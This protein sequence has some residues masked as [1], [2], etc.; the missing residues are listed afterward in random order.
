[1]IACAPWASAVRASRRRSQQPRPIRN[2]LI[3]LPFPS[4][5]NDLCLRYLPVASL[6]CQTTALVVIFIER[7]CF[8]FLPAAECAALLRDVARVVAP[9]VGAS[10]MKPLSAITTPQ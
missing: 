6:R 5:L 10:A 8:Y 3:D 1:M 7:H 9:S 2:G 4:S